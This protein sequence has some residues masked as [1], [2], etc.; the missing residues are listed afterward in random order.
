ML[1]LLTYLRG[2]LCHK[3]WSASFL[4]DWNLHHYRRNSSSWEDALGL[5][6]KA[7]CILLISKVYMSVVNHAW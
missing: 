2:Q 4:R 6:V 1:V 7:L 3:N 5:I